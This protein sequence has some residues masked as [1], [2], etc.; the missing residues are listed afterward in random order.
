MHFKFPT[1]SMPDPEAH[2]RSTSG[3]GGHESQVNLLLRQAEV[4]VS[5]FGVGIRDKDFDD[6]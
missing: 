5:G 6:S 2:L 3:I 4:S 1:D